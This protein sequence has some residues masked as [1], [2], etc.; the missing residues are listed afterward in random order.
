MREWWG[1]VIIQMKPHSLACSSPPAVEVWF[2]IDQGLILVLTHCAGIVDSSSKTN[3]EAFCRKNHPASSLFL[4]KSISLKLGEKQL[5]SLKGEQPS[6]TYDYILSINCEKTFPFW[7]SGKFA[8]GLD[9]KCSFYWEQKSIFF[10]HPIILPWIL[11]MYI[12]WNVRL[13]P[14]ILQEK[15]IRN[16]RENKMMVCLDFKT[17]SFY[18]IHSCYGFN[19]V[20]PWLP[21]WWY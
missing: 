1:A 9:I 5:F 2:L 10:S 21:M 15:W 6:A 16:K 12:L 19:C 8:H 4:N 14:K 13:V 7:E 18:A 3:S 11:V 20:H 17:D